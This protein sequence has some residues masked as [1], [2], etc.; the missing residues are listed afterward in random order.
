MKELIKDWICLKI[1]TIGL[2]DDEDEAV[3]VP[4]NDVLLLPNLN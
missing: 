3:A 1:L 2:F 4:N